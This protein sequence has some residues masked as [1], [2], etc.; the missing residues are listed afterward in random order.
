MVEQRTLRPLVILYSS[1]SK[2]P[3][4]QLQLSVG[5]PVAIFILNG[6]RGA[7]HVDLLVQIIS[8]T[9]FIVIAIQPCFF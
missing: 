5:E 2:T 3:Q 4:F 9:H 1:K 6:E 8:N 7:D